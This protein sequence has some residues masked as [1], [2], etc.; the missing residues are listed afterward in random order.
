MEQE[1]LKLFLYNEKL[2][3]S[4]IE[5]SL[6]KRSNKIAYH[7]KNLVNKSVLSKEGHFY[8]LAKENLI[9]YMSNKNPAL[10]I[11]LIHMGDKE[12]CFLYRREKRPFK[13][14]L[15][16]PG[17]RIVLGENLERA[18]ERIIKNKFN[19]Q[20]KF[21][22]LHSVSIEHVKNSEGIFQTD[23]LFFVTAK[24]RPKEKIDLTEIKKNKSKIISSD[25]KLLVNDLEKGIEINH[26]LT[27]N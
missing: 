24:P 12:N 21:E 17:G 15:G 20:C 22:K 14:K 27:K 4:Q 5:K 6:K 10:P 25:Y 23:L 18:T 8:R 13:N 16:L 11:I 7:L 1:I 3:F 2:K 19:I 26:F 9:P